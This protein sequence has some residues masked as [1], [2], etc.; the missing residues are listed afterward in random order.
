MH[1]HVADGP[2]SVK[3]AFRFRFHHKP[4]AKM[5]HTAVPSMNVC[6]WFHYVS[7]EIKSAWPSCLA[8]ETITSVDTVT[9]LLTHLLTVSTWP[10][11]R[12]FYSFL[13]FWYFTNL[14][15]ATQG[16]G[17]SG[18]FLKRLQGFVLLIT[19]YIQSYSEN[20]LMLQNW[21]FITVTLVQDWYY[22]KH[23]PLE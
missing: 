10:L 2:L 22:S 3:P 12:G 4:M 11:Y 5:P 20:N 7:R 14:Y 21:G 15:W 9:I 16:F 6:F 8:E 23:Y 13:Q 19:A 17:F 1:K 18:C